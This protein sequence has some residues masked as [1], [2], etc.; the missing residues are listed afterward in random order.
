M[1]S[2]NPELFTLCLSLFIGAISAL[3]AALGFNGGQSWK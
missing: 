3:L 2:I 1:E